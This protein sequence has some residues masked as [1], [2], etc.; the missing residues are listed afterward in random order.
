MHFSSLRWDGQTLKLDEGDNQLSRDEKNLAEIF[1]SLGHSDAAQCCASA[2]GISFTEFGSSSTTEI[3]SR[4]A[5]HTWACRDFTSC[6]G[7]NIDESWTWE[8]WRVDALQKYQNEPVLQRFNVL[9][10]E[11][12]TGEE[13]RTIRDGI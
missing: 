12:R 11:D 5:N 6:L 9:E 3:V 2:M 8:T 10:S 4:R 13:T 7:M 1:E